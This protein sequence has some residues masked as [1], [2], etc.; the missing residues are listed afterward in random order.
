MTGEE[1]AT[2]IRRLQIQRRQ[3]QQDLMREY[4]Q[5]IFH[6]TMR[7]LIDSCPH[8]DRGVWENNGLGWMWTECRWCGHRMQEKSFWP[9]EAPHE[10]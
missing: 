4:D 2:A 10:P 3:K 5:T 6:P 8:E 1:T 9:P 7:E